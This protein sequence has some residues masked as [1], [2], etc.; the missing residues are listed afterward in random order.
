MRHAVLLFLSLVS[1]VPALAAPRIAV[2]P[3][4]RRSAMLC[5]GEAL[6]LC[7]NALAAKDR[8]LSCIVG[9]RRLLT[10]P[11]RAVYDQGLNF[12]QGRD[13]HLTLR[14]PKPR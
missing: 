11:C 5:L 1:A 12:L 4:L 7:P 3:Q 8:G 10:A 14:P 2:P 6:R 13:V 9:Q